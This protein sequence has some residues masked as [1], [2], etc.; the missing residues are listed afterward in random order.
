M[1]KTTQKVTLEQGIQDEYKRMIL[2]KAEEQS[3]SPKWD[4]ATSSLKEGLVHH[5]NIFA[6]SFIASLLPSAIICLAV[7]GGLALYLYNKFGK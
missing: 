4:G 6:S 3:N 1:S 7:F 5:G 2:E